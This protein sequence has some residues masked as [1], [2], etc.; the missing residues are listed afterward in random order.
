MA[1]LCSLGLSTSISL[2]KAYGRVPRE[3][4]EGLKASKGP[5]VQPHFCFL[6]L[7]KAGH[8]ASPDSRIDSIS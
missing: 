3:I 4:E 2:A 5:S 1:Y 6:L 7:A 8:K